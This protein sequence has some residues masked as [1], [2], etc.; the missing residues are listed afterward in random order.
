MK[1]VICIDD[2]VN[3]SSSELFNT[4][5]EVEKE[6]KEL[7]K[8]NLKGYKVFIMCSDTETRGSYYNFKTIKEIQY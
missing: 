1:Y 2:G 6:L 3:S 8:Y 4:M 7:M 5:E